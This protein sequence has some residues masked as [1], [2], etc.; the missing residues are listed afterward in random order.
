MTLSKSFTL[1]EPQFFPLLNGANN[2]SLVSSALIGLWFS[3]RVGIP[4]HLIPAHS[5]SIQ[6]YYLFGLMIICH[7]MKPGEGGA[8]PHK[9][10]LTT[11]VLP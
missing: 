6:S 9:L 2:T 1:S 4:H 10:G 3:E 5:A 8:G 7:P 11:F